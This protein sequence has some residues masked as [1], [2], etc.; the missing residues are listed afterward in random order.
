[1]NKEQR[2]DMKWLAMYLKKYAEVAATQY[3][4]EKNEKNNFIH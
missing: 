4:E 1:M 3:I 2:E